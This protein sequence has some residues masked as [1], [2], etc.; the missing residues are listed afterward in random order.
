[1]HELQTFTSA[2]PLWALLVS[3]LAIPLIL[4][5]GEKRRNLREGWTLLAA[6]LKAGLVWSMLPWVLSGR[7][8]QISLWRISPGVELALRVDTLGFVFA[9]V[10]STL[11]LLTSLYS[12]GYM[13]GAREHKQTRYFASFALCLHATIGIAFAANLLTFVIFFEML[14]LATYPLVIHKE[15]PK[16]ID[17]ARKY[18]AFV[19]PAG[20][21]LVLA[22]VLTATIHPVGTGALGNAAAVAGSGAA[23]SLGALDFRAG[24]FLSLN[25]ASRRM[26][27]LIFLLFMLGVGVKAALMPL[28][29][30]LPAA[31][32]APTPV[33]ALLHAVAVVKAGVFGVLRIVGFVYG[34]TLLAQIGVWQML[35]W[36]AGITL[37]VASFLALRQDNLKRRLAYSTVGHLSYIVLG[38][39]ILTPN[40]M[41]GSVMHL[42]FH[43]T[44]KITLFFCA[45]AIY[46][47]T[48]KENI[49][50]MVGIGRQMP[51]T[52]IAF[53]IASL[54]LAGVPGV[55][56][57][58]SKW[59]LAVGTVDARQWWF[60]GLLV[61]S[62]VLNA[63]YFFP[64]VHQA[65]FRENAEY[66][67]Y[68]EASWWMVGPLAVTA[69][70]SLVLG[71][72]PNLGAHAVDLARGVAAM[73]WGGG[74]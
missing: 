48:H 55:N 67:G 52:M 9:V 50:E 38:A 56:G 74:S 32:A 23:S 14:S 61:L 69:L 39:A 66:T 12:I 21:M 6:L 30:W 73:V 42:M 19:L 15:T 5:A 59:T 18:L 13:R 28:Q 37:T 26:L 11:W 2:R 47:R 31:M 29:S 33:S 60:L 62:G 53:G 25:D 54:G 40:G 58:V 64:I 43:A 22:T 17:A 1:M 3:L 70:M 49:S 45:G 41:A 46:V 63:A 24:G 8:A 65:F 10:A 36:V 71:L 35:A 7:V 68:G 16:A 20:L 34:P 27:Q 57:F 4:L 51:V 44:M 72:M